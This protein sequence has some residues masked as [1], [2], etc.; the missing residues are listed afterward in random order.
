MNYLERIQSLVL[1]SLHSLLS[2]IYHSFPSVFINSVL[3]EHIATPCAYVLA[4]IIS[5]YNVR[6]VWP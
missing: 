3:L 4:T 2:T 6:D 1:Q 5:F